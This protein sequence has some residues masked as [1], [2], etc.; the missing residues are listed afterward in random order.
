[1]LRCFRMFRLYDTN[2]DKSLDREELNIGLSRYGCDLS[3]SEVN[4]LMDAFDKD[5]SGLIS[6]TELIRAVRVSVAR[7][8]GGVE[9][10]E[11]RDK[12]LT[13]Y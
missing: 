5:G 6:M 7:G 9:V 12:N 1:M 8:Q 10:G 3:N 11:T 13:S 4:A 2:K